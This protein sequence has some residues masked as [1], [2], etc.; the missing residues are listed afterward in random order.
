MDLMAMVEA[1][2]AQAPINVVKVK[3]TVT[4]ILIALVIWSAEQAMDLMTIVIVPLAFL[5]PMIAVM[6]LKNVRK[7]I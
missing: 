5:Q 7:S 6:T 1:I 4:M 3:E 2:V